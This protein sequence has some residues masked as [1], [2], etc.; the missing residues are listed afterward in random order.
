MNIIQKIKNLFKKKLLIIEDVVL[1]CDSCHIP[2]YILKKEYQGKIQ[3]GEVLKPEYCKKANP[4][5]P[6]PKTGV[7]IK[8]FKCGC[9]CIHQKIKY[10]EENKK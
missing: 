2:L 1:E 4:K 6:I 3:I 9:T 8:C 5:M 10:K 7:T